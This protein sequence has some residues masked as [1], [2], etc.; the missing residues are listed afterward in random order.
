M[1]GPEKK[2]TFP[3]RATPAEKMDSKERHSSGDSAIS[4]N[5]ENSAPNAETSSNDVFVDSVSKSTPNDVV[6]VRGILKT[7]P[8]R[9]RC[10]SESDQASLMTSPSLSSWYQYYETFLFI[11]HQ[12]S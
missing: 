8:N 12:Q 7:S 11:G 4:S 1:S 6:P 9:P 5:D 2:S 10:F 3:E